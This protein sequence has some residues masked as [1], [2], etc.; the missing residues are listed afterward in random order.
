MRFNLVSKNKIEWFAFENPYYIAIN[1][2]LPC[3]KTLGFIKTIQ[4]TPATIMNF[5]TL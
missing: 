5:K 3:H 2:F 4:K 1:T